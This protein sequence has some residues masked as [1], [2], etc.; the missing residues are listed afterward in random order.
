[1]IQ[2]QKI[3][4]PLL[5][6]DTQ[7]M[8]VVVAF[9]KQERGGSFRLEGELGG[10]KERV[11]DLWNANFKGKKGRRRKR[12][13]LGSVAIWYLFE[14][15]DFSLKKIKHIIICVMF[16]NSI[17]YPK[18]QYNFMHFGKRFFA[19][20]LRGAAAHNPIFQ[21]KQDSPLN[22]GLTMNTPVH[23]TP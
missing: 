14:S 22:I 19:L 5:D 16:K 21:T 3:R 20:F 9:P 7:K 15:V 17:F 4:P 1:M 11:F 12:R 23:Y 10:R 8:S 18:L 2:Q 6:L 13:R